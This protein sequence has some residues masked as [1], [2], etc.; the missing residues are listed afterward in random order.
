MLDNGGVGV[1]TADTSIQPVCED[2]L[3]Q[4]VHHA[5]RPGERCFIPSASWW[6]YRAIADE[7]EGVARTVTGEAPDGER[8]VVAGDDGARC[9]AFVVPRAA[10]EVAAPSKR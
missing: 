4:A 7:V 9:R 2:I 1:A 8:P 3:K 5:I 6:Y 10:C